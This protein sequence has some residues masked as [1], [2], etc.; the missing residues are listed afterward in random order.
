[1]SSPAIQ[2]ESEVFHNNNNNK[3]NR[4]ILALSRVLKFVLLLALF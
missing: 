2:L 3:K 4:F 1:M